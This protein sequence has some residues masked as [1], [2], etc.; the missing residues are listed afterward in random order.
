MRSVMMRGRKPCRELRGGLAAV[1]GSDSEFRLTARAKFKVS[2]DVEIC[3][4]RTLSTAIRLFTNSGE[5]HVATVS[6]ARTTQAEGS[7]ETT[8]PGQNEA[9]TCCVRELSVFFYLAPSFT[10]LGVVRMDDMLA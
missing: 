9:H 6:N 1:L 7:C 4:A 5:S 8:Q 2:R 10:G 3:E